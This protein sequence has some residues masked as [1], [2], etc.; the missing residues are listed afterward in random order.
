VTTNLRTPDAFEQRD[1]VLGVRRFYAA[2]ALA[3]LYYLHPDFHP[4]RWFKI[5]QPFSRFV[6]RKKPHQTFKPQ[7]GGT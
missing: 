6:E 1:S 3:T 7:S 5:K 4:D 2:L